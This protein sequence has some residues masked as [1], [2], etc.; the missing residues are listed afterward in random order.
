MSA[1]R[2]LLAEDEELMRERLRE[3]LERVWPELAIVAEA[4][5]GVE[6][7]ELFERHAP[8]LVFL[9]IRMPGLSGLELAERIGERARIVFVTAYDQYALQAFESG[10][11]DYLLKPVEEDRLAATANRVRRR[12]HEP[13]PDLA[14]LLARLREGLRA[15]P[16][17]RMQWIKA[18]VGKDLRLIAV[19]DV[20]F[21]QSDM[22]YTRVVM[23]DGE[24]LIRTPLKELL[25]SLDPE[26]FWQIHRATI[27][28]VRAVRGVEREG[29]EKQWI[30]LKGRPERLALSRQFY[31][32]FRQM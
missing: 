23:A 21:F 30:V 24:A 26:R 27:V 31:H 29:P 3:Q 1:I 5:D 15:E 22:K 32:L 19:D 20:L 25:S 18:N 4:R 12:W 6:A 11:V 14:P 7:M 13:V 28:N 8:Q 17:Q 9:D 2:A 10:A 16:A